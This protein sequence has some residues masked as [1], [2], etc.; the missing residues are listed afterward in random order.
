MHQGHRK[1]LHLLFYFTTRV[2]S[3]DD[4]LI[5]TRPAKSHE[6]PADQRH[7]LQSY[8]RL[9]NATHA[10]TFTSGEQDRAD[11]QPRIQPTTSF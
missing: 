1:A 6:L 7:A 3:Y 10:P 2:A 8:Q 11:V 9:G 4:H 5:D